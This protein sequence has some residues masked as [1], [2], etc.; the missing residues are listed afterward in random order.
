MES[1]HRTDLHPTVHLRMSLCFS[2]CLR[3]LSTPVVSSTIV[4]TWALFC[5]LVVFCG[6]FYPTGQVVC[7]GWF[8]KLVRW[9]VRCFV[10]FKCV[11]VGVCGCGCGCGCVC[12]CVWVWVWVC[13]GVGVCARAPP[14]GDVMSLSLAVSD[15]PP[16]PHHIIILMGGRFQD[17]S[18]LCMHV[19]Q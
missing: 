5:R 9:C 7:C 14:G 1:V 8:T 12:L 6:C 2:L 4:T 13:V 16:P 18:P 15:I 11:C 10:P 17:G 19:P 3:C